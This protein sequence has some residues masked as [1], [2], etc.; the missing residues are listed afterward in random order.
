MMSTSESL[1]SAA[2]DTIWLASPPPPFPTS[3]FVSTVCTFFDRYCSGSSRTELQ[4][5]VFDGAKSP[6]LDHEAIEFSPASVM[7]LPSVFPLDC[8]QSLRRSNLDCYETCYDWKATGSRG[9]AMTGV[10]LGLGLSVPYGYTPS[11][12]TE[13]ND[14]VEGWTSPTPNTTP[15]P[16]KGLLDGLLSFFDAIYDIFPASPSPPPPQHLIPQSTPIYQRSS[17]I[18]PAAS[19]KRARH[20]P[21]PRRPRP[22]CSTIDIK[23]PVF[24]YERSAGTTPA[25]TRR[26]G[27]AQLACA[28]LAEPL[29]AVVELAPAAIECPDCDAAKCVCYSPMSVAEADAPRLQLSWLRGPV[30]SAP[31]TRLPPSPALPSVIARSPRAENHH[32]QVNRYQSER[33]RRSLMRLSFGEPWVAGDVPLV[34]TPEEERERRREL[35]VREE[36]VV[37]RRRWWRI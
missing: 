9:Q 11:A 28:K 23:S 16:K 30:H 21:S 35:L 36:R 6:I 1:T 26:A 31:Y 8:D 7:Y 3:S 32:C 14:L 37:E 33:V 10:G 29:E 20:R 13:R 5:P 19:G 15:G 27:A 25:S 4:S 34:R 17:P 24:E 22:C 12:G 18:L 2:F